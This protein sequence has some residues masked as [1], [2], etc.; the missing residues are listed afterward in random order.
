MNMGQQRA[1][2]VLMVAV[3]WTALPALATLSVAA[4]S[5]PAC[6]RNMMS[7]CWTV[8]PTDHACCMVGATGHLVAPPSLATSEHLVSFADLPF[9]VH[10]PVP[11]ALAGAALPGTGVSPPPLPSGS[12]SILRI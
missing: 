11:P 1:R 12:R 7:C 8:T 3:L 10:T 9:A 4:S 2:I 6:C 5:R